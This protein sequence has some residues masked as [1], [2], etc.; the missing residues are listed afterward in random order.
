M[1]PLGSTI[2]TAVVDK[3]MKV[4]ARFGPPSVLVT[5][6]GSQFTAAEMEQFLKQLNIRHVHSSPLYPRS[7]GMVERLHRVLRER[8]KGLRPSISFPR[9]LQQVLMDIRNSTHRMLGTTPSEALFGRVL[10]TRVPSYHHPVMI[11]LSHQLRAKA[12]M[13]DGHDARRGGHDARR[14]VHPL[15]TLKPGTTVILQDGRTDTTKRWRVVEQYGRQVGCR[16][17]SEFCSR[18]HKM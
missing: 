11:N 13:A 1:I 6:N 10:L 18:I 2:A 12:K 17:A 3:L 8:L 16:T 15:P 4:F 14:G 9:R 5:D 7:N